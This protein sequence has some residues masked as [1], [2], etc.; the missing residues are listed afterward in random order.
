MQGNTTFRHQGAAI[1]SVEAVDAPIVVPSSRF[2]E[3]LLPTYERLGLRAGLLEEVAGV[4]ERRW[5]PEAV[6]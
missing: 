5:W 4:V 6:S 3:V 2:D 1:V